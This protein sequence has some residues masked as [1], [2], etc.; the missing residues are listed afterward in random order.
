MKP[1]LPGPSSH[2]SSSH[3][4]G[5]THPVSEIFRGMLPAQARGKTPIQEPRARV[6]LPDSRVEAFQPVLGVP[7][8]PG[9]VEDSALENVGYTKTSSRNWSV[10]IPA[11]IASAKM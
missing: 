11:R 6:V 1:R 10:V 8:E 9:T 7:E 4:Q 2:P 5:P 3:R